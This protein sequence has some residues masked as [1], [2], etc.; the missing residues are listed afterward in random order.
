[1]P[2]QKGGGFFSFD[3]LGLKK[4]AKPEAA[5]QSAPV[6]PAAP[7]SAPAPALPQVEVAPAL[8]VAQD[9]LGAYAAGTLKPTWAATEAAPLLPLPVPSGEPAAQVAGAPKS[10]SEEP[11][12]MK[13]LAPIMPPAPAPDALPEWITEAEAEKAGEVP[14]PMTEPF[15]PAAPQESAPAPALPQAEA[16]PAAP[17]V[18]AEVDPFARSKEFN[19]YMETINNA[20]G[21]LGSGIALNPEAQKQALIAVAKANTLLSNL[22]VEVVRSVILMRAVAA[23]KPDFSRSDFQRE[24]LA[25]MTVIKAGVASKG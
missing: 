3:W 7:E 10:E 8:P 20:Q 2:E 5:A 16:A 24:M 23:N 13:E 22:P 21:S 15:A 25:A 18:K 14:L 11:D 9:P 4:A 17:E 19:G 1:M 12:W 6:A